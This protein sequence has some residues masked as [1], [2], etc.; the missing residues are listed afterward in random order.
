MKHYFA[1]GY[2]DKPR[3]ISYWHQIREILNVAPQKV[4][5]IGTGSGMV[6]SYL[7][8][9]N[10]AITS[11]DNDAAL[12]PDI[13]AGVEHIPCTDNSYDVVACYEVLEH[14]PYAEV[15]RAL[16]ELWRV[17]SAYVLLSLP[18]TEPVYRIFLH[19]PK[20]TLLRKLIPVPS[21]MRR[22]RSAEP[23]SS[24]RIATDHLWEIGWDGYPL[25][26]IVD[27]IQKAGFA[28]TK[29]YRIFENPY[30]RFFVLKK[31]GK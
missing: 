31:Q 9:R 8:Q 1:P 5:E 13:V 24:E 28:I 3:F 2:D 23:R 19:S 16:R 12:K 11:L 20:R 29:T 26:K 18:D 25:R 17:S 21:F 4:L 27:D 14:I 7:K 15:P 30:H 6:Y 22:R 10:I